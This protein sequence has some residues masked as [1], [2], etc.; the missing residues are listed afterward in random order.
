MY[1][2]HN[3]WLADD[4]DPFDCAIELQA[5]QDRE[6]PA[7]PDDE[8]DDVFAAKTAPGETPAADVEDHED[9]QVCRSPVYV[10]V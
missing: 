4:R 9:V 10:P 3:K 1:F 8:E 2:H 6:P 7:V 5:S